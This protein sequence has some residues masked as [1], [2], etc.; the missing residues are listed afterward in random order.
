MFDVFFIT[1]SCP[2]GEEKVKV[3]FNFSSSAGDVHPK[4]LNF[5]YLRS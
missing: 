1:Y 5:K 3:K 2:A 4:K